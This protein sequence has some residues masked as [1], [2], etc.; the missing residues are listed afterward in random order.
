M[1]INIAARTGPWDVR[2]SANG[3]RQKSL[4]CNESLEEHLWS[5]GHFVPSQK[6]PQH[7]VQ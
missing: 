6:G 2:A 4:H 1:I 7:V 3:I 5:K